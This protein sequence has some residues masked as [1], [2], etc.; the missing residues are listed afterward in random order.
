[1]K[2]K[3]IRKIFVNALIIAGLYLIVVFNLGK[4]TGKLD[5]NISKS[6]ALSEFVVFAGACLVIYAIY[7]IVR[8]KY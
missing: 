6:V 8:K 1:M 7:L 3:W 2:S 4:S 5:F